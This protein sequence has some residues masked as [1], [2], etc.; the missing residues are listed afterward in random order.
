MSKTCSEKY[1]IAVKDS[2][3]L[4][5]MFE[6]NRSSNGD[7]YV[8]FNKRDS[9]H[10]PHSSYHASGQLHH[11]SYNRI[12]F[13]PIHKQSPTGNFNGSEGI[14]TTGIRKGDG[15]AWNRIC[16]PTRYQ[17]IMEIRDEIIVPEFGYQLLFELVEPDSTTWI[18]TDLYTRVIQQH[19][20]KGNSPWIAVTLYEMS[21]VPHA[22]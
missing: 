22:K 18:S 4:F 20:F 10:K 2:Q 13:P 17:E 16:I 21:N 19:F 1:A 7:V 3:D 15:R 8:N 11:K 6:I 5:L 12:L 14:I 9:K